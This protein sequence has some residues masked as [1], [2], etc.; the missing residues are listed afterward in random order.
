MFTRPNVKKLRIPI[1]GAELQFKMMRVKILKPLLLAASD[2]NLIN[3]KFAKLLPTRPGNQRFVHKLM[4][5][6][7]SKGRATLTR[8]IFNHVLASG[9]HPVWHFN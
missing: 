6:L 3:F 7:N 5:Q 8:A 9:R 2:D 4:Q 1:L